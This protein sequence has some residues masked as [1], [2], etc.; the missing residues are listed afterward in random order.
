MCFGSYSTSNALSTVTGWGWGAWHP[1]CCRFSSPPH[2][3]APRYPLPSQQSDHLCT[4]RPGCLSLC[5]S[6]SLP[7]SCLHPWLAA[8][9]RHQGQISPSLPHSIFFSL[10][11]YISCPME[12]L[13]NF[14]LF[15]SRQFSYFC[16]LSSCM[17]LGLGNQD[18]TQSNESLLVFYLPCLS[19]QYRS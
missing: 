19:V 10:P 9:T 13:S 12:L 18:A 6:V 5:R 3:P 17:N 1:A 11:P 15:S 14:C 8:V 2:I 4:L 7:V 16:S